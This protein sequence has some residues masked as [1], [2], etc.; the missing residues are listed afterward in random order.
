MGKKLCTLSLETYGPGHIP[1]MWMKKR[2]REDGRV[3]CF[4]CG[5]FVKLRKHV[6]S[7]YYTVV[8]RH[9]RKEKTE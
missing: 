5:K 7:D 3:P 2:E 8:P 4:E 1:L 9:L 6:A